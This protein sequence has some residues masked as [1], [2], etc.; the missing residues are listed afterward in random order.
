MIVGRVDANHELMIR[1][2]L[3][4]AAGL[5]HELVAILDTGFTGA[6]T[7][8]SSTLASLGLTRHSTGSALTATGALVH[9][10]LYPVTIIWDGVARYVFAQEINSSPLLGLRMLIGYDL[11]A[12]V[13]LGGRV[14]L[15]AIP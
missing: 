1:V 9:F 7:L 10:D 8:P 15:E 2:T 5:D 12:R 4:D 13:E 11:R 3:Q 6:I 14:E